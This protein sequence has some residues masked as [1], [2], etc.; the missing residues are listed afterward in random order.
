M[1]KVSDSFNKGVLLAGPSA[2][3]FR[4]MYANLQRKLEM[5]GNLLMLT[6][7]SDQ[8]DHSLLTAKL[9]VCFAEQGKN[10]LL[11]DANIRNPFLHQLMGIHNTKGLSDVLTKEQSTKLYAR[12]ADLDHLSL[13]PAGPSVPNLTEV[14]S[15][16]RLKKWTEELRSNYDVV[17]F[18]APP[19]LKVSDPQ[20]LADYCDGVL[21]VIKEKQTKREQLY[22]AKKLLQQAENDILGVIYQT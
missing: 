7:P 12:V 10:T 1:F 14:W 19:L 13:L 2:E 16:E 11:V 4:M 22:A 18:D 6:S 17:I 8:L 9:A 5:N 15:S 20:L 21:L 3:S